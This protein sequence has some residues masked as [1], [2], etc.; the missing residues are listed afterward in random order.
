MH[1]QYQT[2]T[3]SAPSPHRPS[4]SSCRGIPKSLVG[5]AKIRGDSSTINIKY[6]P[7]VCILLYE[8]SMHYIYIYIYI[9]IMHITIVV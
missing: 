3:P 4:S 1:L 5:R 2:S 9:Y 7:R 8:R 6:P